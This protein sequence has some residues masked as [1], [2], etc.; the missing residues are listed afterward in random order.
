MMMD[1]V[2]LIYK[3]GLEDVQIEFEWDIKLQYVIKF[4]FIK[5]E[6]DIRWFCGQCI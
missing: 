5:C 2:F 6:E 3:I 1:Y 4:K